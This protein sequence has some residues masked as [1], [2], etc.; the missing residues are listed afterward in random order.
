M[1]H[2]YN[3]GTAFIPHH[4]DNEPEIDDG[5]KIV[6]ISF[7]DSRLME[8]RNIETGSKTCEKLSHGDVLVT[9]TSSQRFFTHSILKSATSNEMRLSVTLRVINPPD[10]VPNPYSP[11]S[12]LSDLSAL[13]V[14]DILEPGNPSN[15]PEDVANDD[16]PPT[17]NNACQQEILIPSDC[18]KTKSYPSYSQPP[19]KATPKS[20]T[21]FISD[22]MF[23]NLDETRLSSDSQMAIKFFYPGAKAS[24]ILEK[25]QQDQEFKTL[26]KSSVKKVFILAGTNDIDDVY[27]DRNGGSLGKTCL[28]LQI[29]VKFVSQDLPNSI[30]NVL[31]ILPRKRIGRC[32]IINE[33]NMNIKSL[34][35]RDKVLNF[36]DTY[37]NQMFAHR[38]GARREEFF[39]QF[40]KFGNDDPHLNPIGIVRLGKY[41]KYLVHNS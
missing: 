29:L 1:I 12:S 23:R 37:S 10:T 35:S 32:D 24:Q 15:G 4:S 40:N 13:S 22:S 31:N 11:L 39:N 6:T 41:L 30:V 16:Q 3:D 26:D 38:D 18:V 20:K 28:D 19:Q 21:L 9:E 25:L 5:S 33:I 27:Y 7:G 2:R 14:S 17:E 36:V 8:F 34:C